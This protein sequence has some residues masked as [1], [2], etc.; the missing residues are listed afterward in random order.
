MKKITALILVLALAIGLT[1]C[2]GGE[3]KL[4]NAFAKMQDITSAESDTEMAFTLETEGFD[5]G[6]QPILKE[7]EQALNNG[8]LKVHQKQITNKDKTMAQAEAN[9]NLK[10]NDVDE[11]MD[12]WIDM[13]A[14]KDAPKLVEIFRFPKIIMNTAFPEEASKEYIVYDVAS[15]LNANNEKANMEELMDFSQKFQSQVSEFMKSYA[16]DYK[17]DK[18]IITSKGD[19]LIK[20]QKLDIYELKLDDKAL[21]ELVKYTVN[22]T[23]DREDGMKLIKDYMDA[24]MKLSQISEEDKVETEKEIKEGL[25]K[26]ENQLP[27]LK[28]KFNEFME[29]YKNVKILGDKGIVMEFGIDRDG[30]IAYEKGS[31]NLEINLADIAKH[32]DEESQELKGIVKFG[33]NYES[34]LSN[35]NNK[36]LKVEIPKVNEENSI[37]LFKMM[38]TKMKALEESIEKVEVTEEV[39]T[40][41]K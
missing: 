6:I 5:E 35:I 36:A 34:N 39:E 10:F 2:Y 24:V 13:D 41:E 14:S 1:G 37:D 12:I 40:P 17:L 18:N 30:Y 11:S 26:F 27:E 22:Y 7:V 32:M 19:K 3:L 21:K 31:I 8:K 25:E 28:E 15:Q 9:M 4:Y 20:G 16:K 29:K 38:E 23:L 33:I